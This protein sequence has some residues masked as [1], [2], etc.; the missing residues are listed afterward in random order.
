[1]YQIHM[2][3]IICI[4]CIRHIVLCWLILVYNIEIETSR[5]ILRSCFF[6]NYT[7]CE[8]RHAIELRI[9][10]ESKIYV[11]NNIQVYVYNNTYN[12]I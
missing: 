2:I 10:L 5:V 6:F 9:D 8:Q 1:M 12:N 4:R 11:Y 3:V 7:L